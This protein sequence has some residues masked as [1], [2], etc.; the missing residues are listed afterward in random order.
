[1]LLGKAKENRRTQPGAAECFEL[2]DAANQCRAESL[3]R[4]AAR[5][6]RLVLAGPKLDSGESNR[7][8]SLLVVI[9]I[10]GIFVSTA[11]HY[12]KRFCQ[13][14]SP[15]AEL[16]LFLRWFLTGVVVPIALWFV[17]NTGFLGG[18]VWPTVAPMSAGASVWWSSFQRSWL[19]AVFLVSSYW[20]GVTFLWLLWRIFERVGDRRS[21]LGTCFAWS[22]L[23]VPGM[24]ILIFLGGWSTLGIAL[25]LCGVGLVH[26]TLELQQA[27][28]A[29]PSYARA[30]ARINFGRYEEAELEVIHELEQCEDDFEGW[31]MLA[32]LYAGHFNDLRTAGQ[33]IRELCEQPATT[34]VQVSIALNRL[35]DWHLKLAHDPVTARKVLEE[36]CARVPGT[37][38]ERMAQLRI[39]QLPATREEW[40]AHEQGKALHLPR[41][42]DDENDAPDRM[43]REQAVAAANECV[44]ALR[45][46]PDDTAARERFAKLLAEQLDEPT[47]AI[48]QMEL[49]LKMPHTS[50][51]QRADWL[52]TIA[53]WHARH[54]HDEQAA[55]LVYERVL[56]DFPT[57]PASFSAQCRLNLVRLKSPF[58]RHS[59]ARAGSPP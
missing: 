12:W 11:F 13:D 7:S 17:F 14:E 49:L 18:P 54:C 51:S 30:I 42:P 33:T 21:F 4:V 20:S 27:R 50:D 22:V 29:S 26:G 59:P 44:E 28:P 1:M 31:M 53:G 15:M 6:R 57:T 8:M 43:P 24:L 56:R 3:H 58:R 46:N 55:T 25:A 41:V 45:R 48:A 23:L 37:H 2:I 40:L 32:E 52:V 36:L 10:A 38:L 16:T 39:H 5:F 9:I 47:T 34:P 19:A 35:A